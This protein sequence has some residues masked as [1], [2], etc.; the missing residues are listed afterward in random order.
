MH[1]DNVAAVHCKA[2]KG[3]TGLIICS[4]L[5]HSERVGT[6][7][8]A[9]KFYGSA[10]TVDSHGV[11]IP[12]QQRYINY[13]YRLL[14]T[15]LPYR[16]RSLT[17]SAIQVSHGP[18]REEYPCSNFLFSISQFKSV[19]WT[20]DVLPIRASFQESSLLSAQT[21]VELSGDVLVECHG[22]HSAF[23]LPLGGFFP[24]KVRPL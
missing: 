10:R 18:A 16:T 21:P 22:T 6:P 2:G 3:R 20:S 15:A 23:V 7:S 19:V 14:R 1:P 24:R 4:Y 17:F 5:L 9:L 11:T 8:E 12:S 13:Y